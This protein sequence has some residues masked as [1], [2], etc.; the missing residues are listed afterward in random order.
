MSCE[1]AA[2]IYVAITNVIFIAFGS[3]LIYCGKELDA[4]SDTPV[5]YLRQITTDWTAVPFVDITVTTATTCPTGSTEVYS[6]P[7]YGI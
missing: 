3:I 4:M 7:W 6:R 2:I 5:D 1:I